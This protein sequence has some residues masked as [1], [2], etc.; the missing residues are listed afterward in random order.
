MLASFDY[1]YNACIF[2]ESAEDLG[3]VVG[4]LVFAMSDENVLE[5]RRSDER[6]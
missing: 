1:L 3:K 4:E 2:V 6:V 5:N